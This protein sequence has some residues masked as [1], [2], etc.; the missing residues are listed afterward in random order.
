M[1]TIIETNTSDARSCNDKIPLQTN[2][3]LLVQFMA[4]IDSLH[5]KPTPRSQNN[6]DRRAKGRMKMGKW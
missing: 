4:R 3:F 2:D 6:S 1:D 5:R